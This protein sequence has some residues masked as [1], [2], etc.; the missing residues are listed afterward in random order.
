M[1]TAAP[2]TE[3]VVKPTATEYAAKLPAHIKKQLWQAHCEEF[4]AKIAK[5]RPP[6]PPRQLCFSPACPGVHIATSGYQYNWWDMP[7]AFYPQHLPKKQVNPN[8]NPTTL[9]RQPTP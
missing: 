2:G 6:D 1:R 4:E 7:G 8:L 3:A 9:I 5:I